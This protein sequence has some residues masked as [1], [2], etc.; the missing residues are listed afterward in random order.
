MGIGLCG[1]VSRIVSQG[2]LKDEQE[3]WNKDSGV[4]SV[5]EIWVIFTKLG[6]RAKLNF[7]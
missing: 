7:Q 5:K 2:R 6:F 4:N 1:W 3:F